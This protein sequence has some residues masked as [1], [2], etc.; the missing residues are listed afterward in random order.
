MVHN[1]INRAKKVFV[2]KTKCNSHKSYLLSIILILLFTSCRN[3]DSYETTVTYEKASSEILIDKFP[4]P[5]M[6]ITGINTQSYPNDFSFEK[7]DENVYNLIT[8]K[9]IL[10]VFNGEANS[11]DVAIKIRHL[12]KD[13]YGKDS[14][15]NWINIG[16]YSVSE[17]KKYADFSTWNRQYGIYKLLTQFED[18]KRGLQTNGSNIIAPEN[19]MVSD[20][21]QNTVL[22][23]D[24][25]NGWGKFT[26]G[27]SLEH[28]KGLANIS[29]LGTYPNNQNLIQCQVDDVSSY[30]FY[31]YP[32]NYIYLDFDNEQLVRITIALEAYD[33]Q[34]PQNSKQSRLSTGN[35]IFNTVAKDYG[36]WNSSGI[37]DEDKENNVVY[38]GQIRANN[39]ALERKAFKTGYSG[40]V[41]DIYDTETQKALC[42]GD[43]FIFTNLRGFPE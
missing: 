43:V 10:S 14:L 36:N 5:R 35:L 28:I 37:T 31:H 29:F 7:L 2:S 19:Q 27:S 11:S 18:K 38:K 33:A 12:Y 13:K 16:T 42:A 30:N 22:K 1:H 40:N 26:F 15:D 41:A 8:G 39:I 9:G 32:I 23:L 25:E 17:M 20:A 24:K 6:G 34:A 3:K 21:V 4:L